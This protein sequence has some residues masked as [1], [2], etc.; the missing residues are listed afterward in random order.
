[1]ADATP[2]AHGGDNKNGG[3][4]K[5]NSTKTPRKTFPPRKIR[6]KGETDD[7]NG[8][9]FETLKES[10]NSLQFKKTLEAM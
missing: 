9:V 4:A 3:S 1:M 7:L 2:P 10:R 6:F 8:N 5:N